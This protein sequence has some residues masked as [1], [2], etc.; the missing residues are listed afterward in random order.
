MH[1]ATQGGRVGLED[2]IA[3]VQ[4]GLKGGDAGALVIDFD[5]GL[6]AVLDGEPVEGHISRMDIE[7]ASGEL[8]IHDRRPGSVFT[9][10]DQYL[11]VDG[12]MF[13]VR[14]GENQNGILWTGDID[15]G[16]NGWTIPGSIGFHVPNGS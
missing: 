9:P 3:Y 6:N 11:A 10:D 13:G 4:I 5:A 16:L 12:A 15:R 2:A 14:A 7:N 8:P 1:R